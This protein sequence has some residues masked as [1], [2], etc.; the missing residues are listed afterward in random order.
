MPKLTIDNDLLAEEFFEDARIMG[1]MAPIPDYRFCSLIRE[2]IGFNFQ[3]D[4]GSEIQLKR[5]K[6]DYFFSVFRYHE[7][8]SPLEHVLYNNRYDGRYLLPECRHIDFVW[9]I[10]NLSPTDAI[11]VEELMHIIRDMKEVQLLAE[12]SADKVKHKKNLIL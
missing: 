12:L 8:N 10:R 11:A 9:M 1:I 2:N 6:R 7:Q 3:M 5:K 4:I